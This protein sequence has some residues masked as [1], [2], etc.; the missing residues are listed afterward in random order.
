M[1]NKEEKTLSLDFEITRQ[2][3]RGI[4]KIIAKFSD[5]NDAMEFMEAKVAWDHKTKVH[6]VYRLFHDR[7]KIKEVDAEQQE[8]LDSDGGMGSTKRSG[9]SPLATSPRPA[10]GSVPYRHEDDIDDE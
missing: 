9:L 10:G 3:E 4:E 7:K 6:T 5:E 2:F 1:R 8:T